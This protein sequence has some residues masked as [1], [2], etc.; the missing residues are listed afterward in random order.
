MVRRA[1]R[2]R[3]PHCGGGAIFR[4]YWELH[5]HCPT[6]NLRFELEPGYCVGA[7]IINTVV[8]FG[9][10][11]AVMVGGMVLLWPEVPWSVL[12]VATVAVAGLTPVAF[13]PFS[14]TLWLA[15]EASYHPVEEDDFR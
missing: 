2:R 6:C 14:R 11:L 4:T 3:C 15:I 13:H 1:A 12:F 10:L 8:T 7:M 5:A 9:L